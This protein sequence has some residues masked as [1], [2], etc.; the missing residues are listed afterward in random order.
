MG[1][2]AM[3][4]A[5]GAGHFFSRNSVC[6]CKRTCGSWCKFDEQSVLRAAGQRW[7]PDVM[8]QRF[9]LPESKDA[10]FTCSFSPVLLVRGDGTAHEHNRVTGWKM[11]KNGD[12]SSQLELNMAMAILNR[13]GC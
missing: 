11:P 12:C 8:T 1:L 3:N 2:D 10:H 9:T 4:E 6:V 13:I 7:F 5:D